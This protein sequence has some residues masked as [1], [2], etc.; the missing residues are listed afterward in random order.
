[1]N[2]ES[3]K[4]AVLKIDSNL[5][6]L[7]P[8]L[9]DFHQGVVICEKEGRIVY[10]NKIQ[11]Q[12]DDLDLESVH[13]KT[14]KEVYRVDEGSSPTMKCIQTG[15]SVK[16]KACFYRTHLGKI[17][18][19]VHNVFPIFRNGGLTGTIS[20]LWEYNSLSQDDKKAFQIGN[21]KNLNPLGPHGER[22]SSKARGNGTRFSFDS[23]IGKDPEFLKSVNFA[24]MA[25]D[26]P[27]PVML[28]GETGCGKELFAQSIHNNSQRRVHKYLAINCAAIPENLLEGIL[29]GTSKGAFTG[30]IDKPGL[31]EN[32]DGGTLLLDEINSMPIGLQAKLLRVLQEKK[33]RRVGSLN[34]IEIDLKI[35][36]TT[37]EDPET[38]CLE[39]RLRR[40]LLYRLGVVFIRI[41]P[42]RDRKNDFESLICHFLNK[43]NTA[44]NKKI[45]SIS[46]GVMDLFHGY[47]WPG[48]VRELEHV[49]EG[50]MNMMGENETIC[51]EHLSVHIGNI[52]SPAVP[53]Q[54]APLTDLQRPGK[55]RINYVFPRKPNATND[56]PKKNLAE[57]QIQNEI[58]II[59]KALKESRGNAAK[60]ARNLG[61]SPQLLHH[62]IK[63]HKINCREFKTQY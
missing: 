32:A 11:A 23:I 45:N 26:S 13:K 62:K 5:V 29:F 40:D 39:G 42:L 21:Q 2:K 6:S 33:V 14:V 8:I 63:K 38:A 27:S 3:V 51:I 9:D 43:F 54:Q 55:G 48:N 36:S 56:R 52:P 30:A 60:A 57:I 35:I 4:K 28:F 12:I 34:E 61:T 46:K 37:N 41:P 47:H 53:A 10:F 24:R 7:L 59:K 50:S 19:S 58:D 44:L 49:I 16:G 1:M 25:S 17:V 18:N 20:F 15:K 22:N 31:F